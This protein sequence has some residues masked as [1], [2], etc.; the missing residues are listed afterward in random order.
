MANFANLTN[1][2][3][4][5]TTSIIP[6]TTLFHTTINVF[7]YYISFQVT[8]SFTSNSS[9]SSQ[10]IESSFQSILDDLSS[11][12]NLTDYLYTE[13]TNVSVNPDDGTISINS[14]LE[15]EN[16]M[17]F[18]ALQ[19]YIVSDTFTMNIESSVSMQLQ[20]IQWFSLRFRPKSEGLLTEHCISTL[21]SSHFF[22]VKL[23][24]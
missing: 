8:L 9:I 10:L 6:E 20:C 4:M 7:S 15:A 2:T 5:W 22:V 3:S 12:L 21:I 14:L 19:S 18:N 24:K 17:D 23:P 13:I 1:T 16:E 11:T